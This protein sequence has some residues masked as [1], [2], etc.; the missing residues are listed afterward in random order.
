MNNPYRTG[1]GY[2]PPGFPRSYSEPP[3]PVTPNNSFMLTH[4]NIEPGEVVEIRAAEKNEEWAYGSHFLPAHFVY[5]GSRDLWM[6]GGGKTQVAGRSLIQTDTPCD[7]YRPTCP[8]FVDW[9]AFGCIGSQKLLITVENRGEKTGHFIS[10]MAGTYQ[11]AG[12]HPG[13]AGY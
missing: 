4:I 6:L 10:R 7:T 13:L 1:P 2:P 11:T 12:S 8:T 3:K 9:P 5:V